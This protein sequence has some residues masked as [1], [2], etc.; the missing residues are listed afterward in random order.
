ML[1]QACPQP[2]PSTESPCHSCVV[3]GK[4]EGQAVAAMGWG[5]HL[6]SHGDVRDGLEE[7]VANLEQF[8]A[9]AKRPM[10]DATA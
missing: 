10:T 2:F 6:C 5:K 9:S 1:R 8:S 4:L 3:L 7:V